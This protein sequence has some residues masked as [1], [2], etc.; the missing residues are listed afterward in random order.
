MVL[1]EDQLKVK[2]L[3][4]ETVTLLCKNGLKF[5]SELRIEG[6]IGITVD[7]NTVLLVNINEAVLTAKTRTPSSNIKSVSRSRTAV[8]KN[9]ANVVNASSG[10]RPESSNVENVNVC[11]LSAVE[12]STV[13]T[14]A[15]SS[16]Q[17]L[18]R[19][20][21]R[22]SEQEQTLTLMVE[23]ELFGDESRGDVVKLESEQSGS[24]QRTDEHGDG[25]KFTDEYN[26]AVDVN[27]YNDICSSWMG[28]PGVDASDTGTKVRS[29]VVLVQNIKVDA[30][31]EHCYRIK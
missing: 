29:A 26:D 21:R 25:N 23:D 8:P 6:L 27:E 20:R 12:V 11:S 3:L 5:T 10:I 24:E 7:N 4:A 22:S 9:S 13:S 16:R 28:Q 18:K 1:T 30:V 14:R 19:K 31:T 2:A 15:G 17:N